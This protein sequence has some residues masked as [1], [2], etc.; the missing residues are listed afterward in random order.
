ML[1]R[2]PK[3]GALIIASEVKSI[4]GSRDLATSFDKLALI[5][6]KMLIFVVPSCQYVMIEVLLDSELRRTTCR[7]I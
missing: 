5:K 3:R 2:R 4:C 7:G 6:H 1:E